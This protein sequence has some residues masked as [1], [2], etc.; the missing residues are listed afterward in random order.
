MH[1]VI[2]LANELDLP[3]LHFHNESWEGRT[4]S[5]LSDP[6]TVIL[7]LLMIQPLAELYGGAKGLVMWY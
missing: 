1:L 2:H 5:P 7:R 3:K 4:V 6:N